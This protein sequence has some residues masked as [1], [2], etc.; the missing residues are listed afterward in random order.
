MQPFPGAPN[1]KEVHDRIAKLSEEYP[2]KIFG[3][4]SLNPYM[5]DEEYKAE[6]ERLVKD[7]GFVGVKIH[8]AGHAVNPSGEAARKVFET[9]KRLNI[10]VM[11]HTGQGVQFCLPSLLMGPAQEYP[12]LPIILAHSAYGFTITAEVFPVTNICKNL[13]LE[14]SWSS[15]LEKSMFLQQIGPDRILY[16]SD[17]IHLN[18]A[19]ELFQF[20]SLGLSDEDLEKCL[21]HNAN[22]IFKLKL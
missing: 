20:K 2:G 5:D 14:T 22:R 4:A 15:I 7:H 6:L 9:A 17:F 11:V 19:V 18:A 13:Y 12:D 8:T 21:F 16:G 10:P 1:V 3:L